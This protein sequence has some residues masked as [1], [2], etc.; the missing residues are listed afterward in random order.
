[1]LRK[2]DRLDGK[3]EERSLSP[4]QVL[5]AFLLILVIAIILYPTTATGAIRLHAEYE[6]SLI[7]TDI[8]GEGPRLVEIKVVT[9]LYVSFS[10]IRIHAANQ[11]N[12]SGWLP[13]IFKTD[14]IDLVNPSNKPKT[15]VVTPT[16]PVGQYN[17]I[18]IRFSN[19]TAVVNGTTLQV[20][21]RPRFTVISYPFTV[22]SGSEVN[23]RL[24]FLADYR[25][26]N[27]SKRV[28]FEVKPILD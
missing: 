19:T 2:G 18:M 6:Q 22:K 16:V 12:D 1:M 10:E 3:V 26:I 27:V 23:L 21:T 11:E 7:Q 9:N 15:I 24:K 8:P 17:S 25:A 20:D 5:S 13:I 14:S 4:R 28:F